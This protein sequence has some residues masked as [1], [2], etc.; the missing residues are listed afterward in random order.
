MANYTQRLD[1]IEQRVNPNSFRIVWV[2]EDE[3]E[4]EA[5]AKAGPHNGKTIFV[6]W[7]KSDRDL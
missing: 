5:N 3:T 7:L 2:D 1:K 6:R 4:A